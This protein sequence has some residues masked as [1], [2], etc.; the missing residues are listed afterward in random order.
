MQVQFQIRESNIIVC[1]HDQAS[2]N[3]HRHQH[4]VP[5][6]GKKASQILVPTA[7]YWYM[8]RITQW[9]T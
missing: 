8:T 2:V 7:S 6:G 5:V 4:E 3:W 9:D 1:K